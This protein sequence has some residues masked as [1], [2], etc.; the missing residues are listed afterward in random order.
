MFSF[1]A[2]PVFLLVFSL[3]VGKQFSLFSLWQIQSCCSSVA[4]QGYLKVRTI[5]L[6]VSSN[7]LLDLP[8][9][10]IELLVWYVYNMLVVLLQR[11]KNWLT[12]GIVYYDRKM[13]RAS[14]LAK[15]MV[16]MCLT[17]VKCICQCRNNAR[18]AVPCRGWIDWTHG[19]TLWILPTKTFNIL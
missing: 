12:L 6:S 16:C 4:L 9:E 14:N 5:G 2:F 18:A 1:Q 13:Q 8:S 10:H 15:Y 3:H 11:N 17:P 7:N 19:F